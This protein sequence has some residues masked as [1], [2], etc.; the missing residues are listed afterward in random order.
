MTD[1]EY[2]QFPYGSDN[3]GVLV[4]DPKTELTLA[5]DAGDADAYKNCLARKGMEIKPYPYH[6]P[7]YRSYGWAGRIE[8]T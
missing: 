6:P 8:N 1:F 2:Y 3:Y 7:P 4:H 5:I